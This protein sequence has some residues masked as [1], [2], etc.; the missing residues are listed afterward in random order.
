MSWAWWLLGTFGVGGVLLGGAVLI[1]GWPVIIGSK[2]GRMALAAGAVVL[3]LLGLYAKA[4]Q[5]G[6]L[7]ERARLKAVT[8]KEV[9][10]SAAERVRIDALPDSKVDE[11]LSAWDRK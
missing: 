5:A 1:F 4:K 6:R 3:A 7:A 11:E 10:L 2:I 9:G 8:E